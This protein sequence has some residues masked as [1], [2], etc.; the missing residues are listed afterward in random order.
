M[1]SD[2]SKALSPAEEKGPRG[3]A[4]YQSRPR[5]SDRTTRKPLAWWDRVKIL[6]LLLV[7]WLLLLW[8]N[9]AHFDPVITF[10]D[11]LAQT[12]RSGAWLLVLA[13]L[14]ILRQIHFFI[15]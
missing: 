11:V 9:A 12:L 6:T 7:A 5:D 3:P 15:C 10:R 4:E 1:S 2:G 14:E 13:G 8:S